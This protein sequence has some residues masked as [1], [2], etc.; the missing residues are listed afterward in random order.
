MA[1]VKIVDAIATAA[2]AIEAIVTGGDH[3]PLLTVTGVFVGFNPVGVSDGGAGE[4][5]G[6]VVTVTVVAEGVGDSGAV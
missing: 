6:A 4:L 2:K 5:L 1:V 3:N